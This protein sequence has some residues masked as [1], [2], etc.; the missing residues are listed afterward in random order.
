[1]PSP[2]CLQKQPQRSKA[3]PTPSEDACHVKAPGKGQGATLALAGQQPPSPAIRDDWS[4]ILFL[5]P[6]RQKHISVPLSSFPK[7][8]LVT[9]G[10]GFVFFYDRINNNLPELALLVVLSKY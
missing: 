3:T 7:D 6:L 5:S 2:N 8:N 9:S 4:T 1:M 10:A